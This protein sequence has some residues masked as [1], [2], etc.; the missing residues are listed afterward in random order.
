MNI[1]D[2]NKINSM[3]EHFRELD[4]MCKMLKVE[5]DYLRL[6][7]DNNNIKNIQATVNQ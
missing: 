5:E 6:T 7:I 4:K 2:I 3:I 1:S